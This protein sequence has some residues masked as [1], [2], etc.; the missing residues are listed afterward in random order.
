[1]MKRILSNTFL[2]LS[3]LLALYSCNQTSKSD[4]G[5]E[6]ETK[7]E[8]FDPIFTKNPATGDFLTEYFTGTVAV[9]SM[10]GN[11]ENNEYSIGNVIFDPKARTN[12]HTHPK[13]QVLLVVAGEGFYKAEGEPVQAISK[14][15]VV[16]IPPDVNH[17]HGAA[18]NSKFV[19][20]AIT[21]YKDGQNVVWGTAVTDEDYNS[22]LP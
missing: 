16:N 21:N 10:L 12:W 2:I 19:H 8:T 22:V 5:T 4:T 6:N 1:M 18:P 17:W 9:N 13:G 11:D 7:T 15:D 14:G 3:A 20:I